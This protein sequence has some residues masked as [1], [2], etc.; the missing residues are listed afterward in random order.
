MAAS[1][2]QAYGGKGINYSTMDTIFDDKVSGIGGIA[3]T[4]THLI[5]TGMS[6]ALVEKLESRYLKRIGT[7]AH[8]CSMMQL[9]QDSKSKAKFHGAP[10][11]YIHLNFAARKVTPEYANNGRVQAVRPLGV[12]AR[13]FSKYYGG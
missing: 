9:F 13:F 4:K 5:K 11:Q 12:G 3:E 7:D 8:V 2:F 10:L 1:V 6:P